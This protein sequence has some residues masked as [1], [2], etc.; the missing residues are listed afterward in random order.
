MKKQFLLFLAIIILSKNIV[1]EAQDITTDSTDL[2][3]VKQIIE[4]TTDWTDISWDTSIPV[5]G[6]TYKVLQGE[7]SI[8]GIQVSGLD[9]WVAKE[10]FDSTRVLVEI[11]TII[12]KPPSSVYLRVE[13]GDI[14]STNIE[15]SALDDEGNYQWV[16]YRRSI[17][18]GPHS[19]IVDLSKVY[20]YSPGSAVIQK[21]VQDLH[22]QVYAFYYPWY[23]NYKGPSGEPF[24]WDYYT[25]DNIATSTNYP[26]LGPYDSYDPRIIMAHIALAKQAGID[27]FIAS[28]W[29][30]DSFEDNALG[31]IL[32]VADSM[33]FGISVYYESV[34][35]MTQEQVISELEYLFSSYGDHPAFLHDQGEPVVFVYVPGYSNRDAEF[36]LQVRENVENQQG[37]ITLIGDHADLDLYPA[38]EAFHTYIYTG[39]H[40]Y[41]VFSEAMNRMSAGV[42]GSVEEQITRLKNG[43]DLLIYLKPFFVTVNPGFWFF[44]KGPGDLLAERNDGE[45]YAE[46]WETAL[47]LDA[48]TVLVTSW[49]EWHEGTEIE[50]SREH[51]FEYLEYTRDYIGEYKGANPPE[52]TAEL[53]VAVNGDSITQSDIISIAVINSPLIA[54]NVSIEC[55]YGVRM[56]GDI[57]SYLEDYHDSG[58]WI[59]IPYIDADETVNITV[60]HYTSKPSGYSVRVQGFDAYGN[61][62]RG[63]ERVSTPFSTNLTCFVLDDSIES[64]GQVKVTGS[65]IPIISDAEIEIEITNPDQLVSSHVVS[66]DSA[67]IYVYDFQAVQQGEW[68][69]HASYHG[70]STHF[71]DDSETTFIVT[72]QK[73]ELPIKTLIFI[74]IVAAAFI[75]LLIRLRGLVS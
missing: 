52:I 38:F 30:F 42:A 45:K 35:T 36:W 74:I 18:R 5:Y 43:E 21:T 8:K 60:T 15:L 70:D 22:K 46:N 7:E 68:K 14:E 6:S 12:G 56:T 9:L 58:G 59:Q 17:G 40:S 73:D 44:E 41:Q 27:G 26:I 64:G 33:D 10:G 11:E 24:H 53:S 69:I 63:V 3:L 48:H 51:G 31:T 39:D 47:E 75:I 20:D 29:G 57:V 61:M 55:D 71:G 66:T 37:P 25:N 19:H 67:G 54:V 1:V 62:Y 72:K 28:W 34:R 2:Y 23:G 4:I 49:N 13:K 65:L 50:P 32:E 16:T